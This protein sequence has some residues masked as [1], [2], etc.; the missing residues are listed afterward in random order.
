MLLDLPTQ[1][2]LFQFQY[3]KNHTWEFIKTVKRRTIL[4]M[5]FFKLMLKFKINANK[6]KKHSIVVLNILGI[7]SPSLCF[8]HCFIFP[9]LSIIPLGYSNNLWIDVFFAC[10]GMSYFSQ[11]EITFNTTLWRYLK[12]K[13]TF[14][15]LV[16]SQKWKIEI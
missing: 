14:T 4:C 9:I 15:T 6:M 10:I 2:F 3:Y 16:H 12:S 8:I 7:S 13:T 11:C 1:K 5:P